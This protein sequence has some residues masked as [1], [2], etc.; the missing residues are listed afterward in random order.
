MAAFPIGTPGTPWG[1]AERVEWRDTRQVQRSYK[2]EVVEYFWV[3]RQRAVLHPG[4]LWP[5]VMV[6]EVVIK[7]E[8]PPARVHRAFGRLT[9]GRDTK[10]ESSAVSA[11]T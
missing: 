11:E 10:K 9:L 7:A 6:F 5:T 2:E 3:S 8:I 4:D 1:E